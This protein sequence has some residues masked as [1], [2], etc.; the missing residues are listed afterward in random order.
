M[1]RYAVYYFVKYDNK[2]ECHHIIVSAKN[3]KHAAM[4][5]HN[6]NNEFGDGRKRII[7]DIRKDLWQWKVED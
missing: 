6:Y 7:F 5:F 3:E 4:I 1:F 2:E